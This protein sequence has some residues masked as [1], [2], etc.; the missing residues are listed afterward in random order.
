MTSYRHRGRLLV[1]VALAAAAAL[2]AALTGTAAHA[3]EDTGESGVSVS[4]PV[5]TPAASTPP[6]PRP[7]SSPPTASGGPAVQS[8]NSPGRSAPNPSGIGPGTAGGPDE[9]TPA[10][11]PAEPEV[12]SSVATSGG[13]AS[14]DKPVY[15]V[16][17]TVIA[18]AG[19]FGSGEQV[20]L[21]LFS[22]PSLIGT[23][24]ADEAGAVK[25][26]FPVADGTLPGPHTLQF[27]GWCG[28]VALADMLVGSVAGSTAGQQGVPQWAWWAGGA[29][30]ALLLAF[31]GRRVLRLM[32]E[33]A[34]VGAGA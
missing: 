2:A 21:V 12:P 17:D 27:D 30:G 3:T 19:G 5:A 33:P 26:E 34:S 8:A 10:C 20:Q 9:A 25:A 31:G 28:N 32:R 13:D 16:G 18:T 22:E 14:V 4:V 11:S 24:T 15:E 1:A 23:F 7:T 6:A 29:A